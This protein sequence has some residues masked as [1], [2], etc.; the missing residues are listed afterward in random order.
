MISKTSFLLLLAGLFLLFGCGKNSTEPEEK[1]EPTNST[2]K[3]VFESNR[4][5]DDEIFVMD[6]DGSNQQ[7]L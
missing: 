1:D 7:Q 4:D 6:I 3:I 2:L 5:G